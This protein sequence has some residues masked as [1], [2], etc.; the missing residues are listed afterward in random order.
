M[1]AQVD[2]GEARRARGMASGHR[3]PA[4]RHGKSPG[5]PHP[6]AR[7]PA[8]VPALV[9]GRLLSFGRRP[10][11]QQRIIWG[12]VLG[13]VTLIILTMG[14]NEALKALQAA[15]IAGALPFTFVLLA[16]MMGLVKS[17]QKDSK[18]FVADEENVK[19]MIEREVAD[20]S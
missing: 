14:G 16:M 4:T 19:R 8:V 17:L 7:R 12:L 2:G 15:S 10:P 18:D 1:A 9:L 13:A 11:V 5:V 3:A 20:L 6:Q